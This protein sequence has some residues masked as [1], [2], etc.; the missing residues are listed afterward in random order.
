MAT[1]LDDLH[2]ADLHERAAAAGIER[3]RLLRRDQLIERLRGGGEDAPE[4]AAEEAPEEPKPRRR[5]L[6]RRRGG[7]SRSEVPK[8]EA[9]R[10]DAEADTD[11][12][13][14]VEAT[15]LDDEGPVAGD[16]DLPT[17]AVTGVLELTRQRFGFLRLEG[18]AP[19]DD[20]VYVSAA[21]VRRCGLRPGDEVSGPARG[22][23][24]GERHRALVHIDTV[25]GE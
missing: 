16:E 15:V 21:Q 3:Y 12:L 10:A 17:E 14:V 20:D 6:R 8:P 9:P 2:L 11:E 13:A 23:R 1:E 19:S 18:L 22:A 25:N 5:R 7:E 24:R 4:E